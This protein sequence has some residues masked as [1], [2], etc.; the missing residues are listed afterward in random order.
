MKRVLHEMER[1]PAGFEWVR[2]DSDATL[3]LPAA[4]AESRAQD[5]KKR[6]EEDEDRHREELRRQQDERIAQAKRET[7]AGAARAKLN[8]V[9]PRPRFTGSRAIRP[10]TTG[11]G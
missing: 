2:I 11:P 5:N 6:R 1:A 8:R 3:L 10:R 9:Q 7:E 4:V